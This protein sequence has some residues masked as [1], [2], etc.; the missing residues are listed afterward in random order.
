MSYHPNSVINHLPDEAIKEVH[1]L[2][3]GDI[4][5][6]D[7]TIVTE[8]KEGV[9]YGWEYGLEVIKLAEEFYGKNF[10]V[11]Y[12]ANR[13][14]DYAVI[15]QDWNRFFEQN[16]QLRSFSIVTHGKTGTTNIAIERLFY[17]EGKIMHFTDLKT[18]LEYTGNLPSS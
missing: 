1:H 9:T 17:K 13:I 6:L 7:K 14:Y 4:I 2:D 11:N 18:A 5:F 15:A 12:L 8:I 3:F 10:Y 16:R